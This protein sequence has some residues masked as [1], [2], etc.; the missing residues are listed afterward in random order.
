MLVFH[1][2][3]KRGIMCAHL[4]L[5]TSLAFTALAMREETMQLVKLFFRC[6]AVLEVTRTKTTM[7]LLVEIAA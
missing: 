7:L 6:G 5:V 2:H 4:G 3:G 1:A